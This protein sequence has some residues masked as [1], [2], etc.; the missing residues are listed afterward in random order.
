VTAAAARRLERLL[1]APPAPCHRSSLLN[2][3]LHAIT[4]SESPAVSRSADDPLSSPSLFRQSRPSLGPSRLLSRDD[5]LPPLLLNPPSRSL[6][7]SCHLSTLT[8]FEAS[9]DTCCSRRTTTIPC[10][11]VTDPATHAPFRPVLSPLATFFLPVLSPNRFGHVIFSLQQPFGPPSSSRS[12]SNP[13]SQAGWKPSL[14]ATLPRS[15]SASL[16]VTSNTIPPPSEV[17]SWRREVSTPSPHPSSE[18]RTQKAKDPY[19]AFLPTG[20]TSTSP[21]LL[22]LWSLYRLDLH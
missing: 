22:H 7:P 2:I 13:L 3:I 19:S 8:L 6:S 18:R 14:R 9:I 16:P 5:D 15:E 17:G 11:I 20:L 10:P 12:Q 21:A 1:F 4:P